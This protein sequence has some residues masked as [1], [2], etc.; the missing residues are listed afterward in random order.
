MVTESDWNVICADWNFPEMTAMREE[1]PTRQYNGYTKSQ[2][3]VVQVQGAEGENEDQ[4][5]WCLAWVRDVIP[6]EA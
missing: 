1:P 6:Y 4:W 3:V 5:T 2:V